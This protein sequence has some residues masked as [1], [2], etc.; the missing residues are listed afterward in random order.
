MLPEAT[1]ITEWRRGIREQTWQ[2]CCEEEKED[3]KIFLHFCYYLG[4]STV[5]WS[6]KVKC[7]LA[8]LQGTKKGTHTLV[9]SLLLVFL[10]TFISFCCRAVFPGNLAV[11]AVAHSL[12]N[13]LI[14]LGER[15]REREVSQ[16]L[17]PLHW[18]C[19]AIA[20]AATVFLIKL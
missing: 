12:M 16:D 8:F 13:A 1:E 14:L 20:T 19:T 6:P 4:K 7:L 17:A 5:S 11:A 9:W 3:W 10:C 15:E 18:H 2:H